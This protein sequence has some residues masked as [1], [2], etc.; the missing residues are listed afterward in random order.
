MMR[1]SKNKCLMIF[2]KM[3]RLTRFRKMSLLEIN[4]IFR[5]I[6]SIKRTKSKN[7]SILKSAIYCKISKKCERRDSVKKRSRKPLCLTWILTRIMMSRRCLPMREW[8]RQLR[9][10]FQAMKIRRKFRINVGIK[11][12]VNTPKTK[13]WIWQTNLKTCFPA[14]NKCMT[15]PKMKKDHL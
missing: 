7:S 11:R 2:R 1:W 12:R 3:K 5:S 9:L 6:K 14:T 10:G 4:L 8:R 13:W 15:P